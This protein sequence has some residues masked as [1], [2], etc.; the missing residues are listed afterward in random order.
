MSRR[1]PTRCACAAPAA[2]LRLA[3]VAERALHRPPNPGPGPAVDEVAE[4]RLA[5]P[6]P[7]VP[8]ELEGLSDVARWWHRAASAT[9]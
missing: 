5:Q 8:P 9:I 4:Y 3:R 6:A 2:V 7:E 1:R